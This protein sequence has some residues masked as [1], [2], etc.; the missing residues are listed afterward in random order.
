MQA[1][2]LTDTIE[3]A[4]NFGTDTNL[5]LGFRLI[6]LSTT[7]AS[8][9][10]LFLIP[11]FQRLF[12]KAVISFDTYRSIPKLVLHSFSKAGVKHFKESI[13]I[14][15][16]NNIKHV[17]S[18]KKISYKILIFNMITVALL[19]IGSLAPLYAG[20]LNPESRLT[21]SSLN[22][23]ITG[24]ATL[25]LTI[26]IDPHLSIMTDDVIEGKK[27]EAEFRVNIIFVVISRIIGT[28]IAQIFFLPGAKVISYIANIL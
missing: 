28:L 1:P 20:I 4:I 15:S 22:A 6:L 27:T 2:L 3:D 17:R 19:T 12:S 5:M 25:L 26:F 18:F 9:V 10:G 11:T 21:A 7:I 14:P 8:I 23:V 16:K 24:L 13:K